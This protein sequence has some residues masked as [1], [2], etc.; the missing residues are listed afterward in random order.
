MRRLTEAYWPS[1]DCNIVRISSED[2]KRFVDLITALGCFSIVPC[3]FLAGYLL[4][5]GQL[6]KTMSIESERSFLKRD[7]HLRVLKFGSDMVIGLDLLAHPY[8]LW[9]FRGQIKGQL[10]ILVQ[11][12]SRILSMNCG[13]RYHLQQ[14]SH[15]LFVNYQ[16]SD[17]SLKL[18]SEGHCLSR[19]KL[20]VLLQD[21]WSQRNT[22]NDE[23]FV[24][25]MYTCVQITRRRKKVIQIEDC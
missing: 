20:D 3:D 25:K 11:E 5:L 1:V 6:F 24:K 18:R 14:T 19:C 7:C 8:F 15:F 16:H 9:I 17:I 13:C 10:T 2:Q 12:T 22:K 4:F 21:D 23:D